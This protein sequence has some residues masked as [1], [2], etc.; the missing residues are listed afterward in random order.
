MLLN[1][2]TFWNGLVGESRRNRHPLSDPLEG[3]EWRGL[4][5]I[6]PLLSRLASVRS[7]RTARKARRPILKIQRPEKPRSLKSSVALEVS[8]SFRS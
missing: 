1:W 6:V 5:W 3:A 2:A 7:R 4:L 8:D